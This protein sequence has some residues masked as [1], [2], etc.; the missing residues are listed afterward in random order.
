MGEWRTVVGG[1]QREG[2]FETLPY[3]NIGICE[4]LC[5][6]RINSPEWVRIRADLWIVP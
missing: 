4:H 3:G 1:R 2:G 5:H 6:L